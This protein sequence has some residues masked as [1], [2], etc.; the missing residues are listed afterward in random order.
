MAA[1][2]SNEYVEDSAGPMQSTS[3]PR[4]VR[5]GRAL[6]ARELGCVM[7]SIIVADVTIFRGHG[8]TGVAVMAISA[9][10]LLW[11][12]KGRLL[13]ARPYCWFV[14]GLL[15][16][17]A[18][19]LAWG[20]S[21]ALAIFAGLLV[22]ALAV[23]L[24]GR[25]PYVIHSL[26]L[27][28]QAAP[29][30]VMALLSHRH[31]GAA[32]AEPAA[33]TNWL[34]VVLPLTLLAL[35]G[36]IFIMANPDL[37]E[38]VRWHGDRAWGQLAAALRTFSFGEVLFWILVGLLTL[39]ALQPLHQR[40]WSP[41][42]IVA[43]AITS[44]KAPSD[45]QLHAFRNSL[46]TLIALFAIYLVF[47][48]RTL[49]FRE[50]PEGFYYAGYAH[51]G[52]AWLTIALA[53]TTVILSIMFRES[54]GASRGTLRLR[55]LAWVWSA[56]NLILAAAVYN[57]MWIYIQF[58]GMTRMRMVGL[59]GITA[60]VIGLLLMLRRLARGHDFVWLAQRYA[61]TVALATLVYLLLP[62][63]MIVHAYNVRRVLAGDLPPVVQIVAHPIDSG[64]LLVLPA[65]LDAKNPVIRDGIRAM[66]ADRQ[67]AI[68]RSV[69]QQ[70]SA[71]WTAW[72]LSDAWLAYQL[73]RLQP[74]WTALPD[75]PVRRQQLRER[76]RSYA[77]Q[78]Y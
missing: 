23:T 27:A 45:A 36:G 24:D 43:P 25:P 42:S 78:W 28:L 63:D 66:L 29:A 51:Q 6:T 20:G 37:A 4:A 41:L 34:A 50:F 76:F 31:T 16:V 15:I 14:V 46:I 48:F 18:I 49:W 3:E 22:A 58:N 72:Q 67:E 26:W 33:K 52:A 61:W 39:G 30:G 35:F 5:A 62:V 74:H 75:D 38:S 56:E 64:G 10:A 57:R 77:M 53:L 47:E 21:L 12:G 65:L 9:V 32:A 69:D 11:L 19:K 13:A 7:V 68:Q 8:Y 44:D 70:R 73:D 55:V 17:A 71:G 59:L 1:E 60:V 2:A 54:Q 40:L